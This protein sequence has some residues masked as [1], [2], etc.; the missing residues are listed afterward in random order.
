M[1]R[2]LTIALNACKLF[3]PGASGDLPDSWSKLL[4]VE[5]WRE[6]GRLPEPFLSASLPF[7]LNYVRGETF[8]SGDKGKCN[9]E[10]V[11]NL[12]YHLLC[13]VAK[14]TPPSPGGKLEN[15]IISEHSYNQINRMKLVMA[16]KFESISLRPNHDFAPGVTS[17]QMSQN[18]KSAPNR[19]W[20][21]APQVIDRLTNSKTTFIEACQTRFWKHDLRTVTDLEEITQVW[22]P[23]EFY[24]TY[25]LFQKLSWY[26][27]N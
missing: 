5:V 8:W 15:L 3:I 7:I 19:R 17:T 11:K 14:L 6:V 22:S 1:P 27:S 10:N 13:Q 16:L 23:T 24:S 9:N 4:T 26:M 20:G 2:L 25:F 21:F 12:M 18:A